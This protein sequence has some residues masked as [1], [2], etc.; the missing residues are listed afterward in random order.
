MRND[1]YRLA[2]IFAAALLVK[3]A[4]I[5]LAGCEIRVFVEVLVDEPLIVTE[6]KVGLRAVLRHVNLAVLIRTHRAGIDVY[7]GVKLLCRYF[8]SSC[9]E[10][11]SEGC[12]RDSLTKPRYDASGHENVLCHVLTLRSFGYL[13]FF[14]KILN[15]RMS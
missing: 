9:F 4:P 14:Y 12:C 6:V 13:L 3:H 2:E 10:Q 15:F 1:L 5:Y 7:V 11:A 8:Q